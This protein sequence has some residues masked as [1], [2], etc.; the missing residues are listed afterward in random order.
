MII[1]KGGFRRV[2]VGDLETCDYLNE[3]EKAH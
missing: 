2:E 3:N 1:L